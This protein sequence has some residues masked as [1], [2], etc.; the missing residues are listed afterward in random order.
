MISETAKNT[1]QSTIP[2]TETIAMGI[3]AEDMEHIMEVLAGLYKNRLLAMIREYS[4][5]AWD[6]HIEAACSLPIEVTLPSSFNPTLTIR[7]YGL[8]LDAEGIR[9]VYS[10]YGRSTKR[11]TN[12]QVGMLGLGSKSALS[13]TN[14]FT[15]VS[16]KDGRRL[17]VLVAVDEDGRGSMQIIGPREGEPTDDANGTEVQVA[18]RRE[19]I[20]RAEREAADFFA[21][22]T[23]GTVLVN[24]KEPARFEGF[25]VSDDLFI[26]KDGESKV[27]MGGVPY[28]HNIDVGAH[29]VNVVAFVPIGSVKP[30][31]SREA[32]KDTQLTKDTLAKIKRDFAKAVQG[33]IQR[34]VDACASPADAVRTIIEWR[35]YVPQSG[36]VAEYVFKGNKVPTEY[37]P[38]GDGFVGNYGDNWKVEVANRGRY[39]RKSQT[40]RMRSWAVDKWPVTLWVYGFAPEKFTAQ[41][42]NKL[43]KYVKDNNVMPI[44]NRYGHQDTAVEHYVLLRGKAPASPFIDPASVVSWDAIKA[45]KLNPQPRTFVGG[46]P[47]IPGSYD[48]WTED[49]WKAG[50]PGSDLRTSLP[51]FYAHGNRWGT[52]RQRECLASQYPKFTLV[53][54]PENRM[55]KFARDATTAKTASEG[56][57][58]AYAAW[59]KGISD[60]DKIAMTLQDR[61][62]KETLAAV[63]AG[64]KDPALRNL[65]KIAQRDVRKLLKQRHAFHGMMRVE[66]MTVAVENP[67]NKYPLY[68]A[69]KADHPHTLLYLNTAYASR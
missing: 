5:N 46:I 34:E 67:L 62:I 25:K 12:D 47:R 1:V 61:G 37:E 2:A 27:V 9:E 29:N 51:L 31:P 32:L 30:V 14:Q 13:Y 42:R 28:P 43:D 66:D 18:I 33:A 49:G 21:Y 3:R 4:C 69:S 11:G 63:P 55:A 24:G 57:K 54:L 52:E 17:T 7:D 8:G 45:I 10:Q 35:Q 23:R 22:W 39:Y 59:A 20:Q 65:R 26:V 15:V 53:A 19:D 41:H 38:E 40:S 58:D 36:T 50:V 16:V 56:I 6:A 48:V 64:V 68:Q 44:T 60:H